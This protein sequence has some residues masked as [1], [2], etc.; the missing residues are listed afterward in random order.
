MSAHRQQAVGE[1]GG[2]LAGSNEHSESP[3]PFERRPVAA[4]AAEKLRRLERR[5]VVRWHDSL[6]EARIYQGSG[7]TS[8]S[9]HAD[10]FARTVTG[11]AAE[12]GPSNP[13]SSSSSR[14][15]TN[16]F[17]PPAPLDT[18]ALASANDAQPVSPHPSSRKASKLP[19][20]VLLAQHRASSSSS[21]TPLQSDCDGPLLPPVPEPLL[22]R[23]ILY[24]FQGI[25]GEFVRFRTCPPPR[26]GPKRTFVRGE[27]VVDGGGVADEA[28]NNG[29]GPD[30]ATTGA[31]EEGIEFVGLAGSG[32]SLPAPTRALL[33]QLSELG[34]L[35]RKIDA[36]L[37]TAADAASL[38]AKG[39][40]R[41]RAG[42]DKG[43]K[44][45]A[46]VVVG[47]VEQSLHAE[48]KKEMTEYFRLVAVLEAKLEG[49]EDDEGTAGGGQALEGLTQVESLSGGL[50]LRKLD[51]WTQDIR[52]RMR[53]MGTL[54]AE[55]GGAFFST[56]PRP[57]GSY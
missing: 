20:A 9:T 28:L 1:T 30:T 8:S 57:P 17:A 36:A 47:M 52:L 35:Y 6:L 10:P 44:P 4:G 39:K 16:F 51:V 24:L 48:L 55:A 49:V 2:S 34:W 22:L 31:L 21:P 26:A 12:A 14:R 56:C 53:M 11:A 15:R 40:G 3:T 37:V 23:D 46:P 13:S 41:S 7:A 32:Y 54:V 19:M 38:A 29:E 43:K 5:R 18:S 25:D 45:V 33:H 42:G 50:T 27:I